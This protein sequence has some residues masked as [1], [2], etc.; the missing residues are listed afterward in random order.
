MNAAPATARARATAGFTLVEML[1]VLAIVAAITSILFFAFARVLDIR[2]RLAA[3]LA[4]TDE[5]TLIAGWFRGSIEGL[6]P[7]AKG[8]DGVFAGSARRFSG[9][10]V[11]AIDGPPG[12]PVAVAWSLDYEPGAGPGGRT[13][14]R[15]Q[16]GTQ[17][18]WTVAS[19]PGNVGGFT[20]CG[21][22]LTCTETWPPP[23]GT[24][25]LGAV[26]TAV[27]PQLPALVRLD[28]VKTDK[29]WPILAAPKA[30]RD[31]LPKLPNLLRP[32]S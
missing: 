29:P 3:F 26:S 30:A 21:A 9:L 27:P 10:S 1:V 2:V 11:A 19:W 5:P 20:Y 24:A 6:M 25:A 13:Y 8:G 14:L 18:Q 4:G 15:Y 28:A 31:P 23:Q 12:V 7:D 17:K 22:G 32:S 16:A